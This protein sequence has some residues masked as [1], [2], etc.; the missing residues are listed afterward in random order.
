MQALHD[1][2]QEPDLEHILNDDGCAA[3]ATQLARGLEDKLDRF[4]PEL[5]LVPALGVQSPGQ[6]LQGA[7]APAVVQH[8][9]RG[10]NNV[11]FDDLEILIRYFGLVLQQRE[12]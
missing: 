1:L 7:L 3:L 6:S 5:N 8:S 9:L 4:C 12:S 2:R 11:A 10:Q